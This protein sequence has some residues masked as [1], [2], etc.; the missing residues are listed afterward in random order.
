MWLSFKGALDNTLK[1]SLI[2]LILLS[3]FRVIDNLQ[4]KKIKKKKINK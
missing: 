3:T 4:I 2:G 1:F